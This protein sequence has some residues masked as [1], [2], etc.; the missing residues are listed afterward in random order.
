MNSL[1]FDHQDNFVPEVKRDRRLIGS[2]ESIFLYTYSDQIGSSMIG[3]EKIRSRHKNIGFLP[4][5]NCHKNDV[6]VTCVEQV[7]V[8]PTGAI[9]I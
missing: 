5:F 7:T 6:R 9:T 3:M 8:I 4:N 1:S 2:L